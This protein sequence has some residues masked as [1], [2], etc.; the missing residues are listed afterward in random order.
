MIGGFRSE[1]VS[2]VVYHLLKV[3]AKSSWKFSGT[4][5][6]GSFQRKIS[7]R[8]RTSEKPIFPDRIFQA[9]IHDVFL[10]SHL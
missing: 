2:V 1:V 8:N 7:W 9:E 3:S 4:H 5:L 10:Q 6:F